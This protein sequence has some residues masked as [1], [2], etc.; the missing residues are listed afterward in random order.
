MPQF[1]GAGVLRILLDVYQGALGISLALIPLALRVAFASGA[2][3]GTCRGSVLA[4]DFVKIDL[5]RRRFLPGL[6]GLHQIL[7]LLWR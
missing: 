7:G 1:A 2:Q 6:S 3:A 4:D 5:G